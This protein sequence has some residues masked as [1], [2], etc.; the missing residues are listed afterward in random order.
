MQDDGGV[1]PNP[2]PNAETQ[3]WFSFSFPSTEVK[4]KPNVVT[5]VAAIARTIQCLPLREGYFVDVKDIKVDANASNK[6]VAQAPPAAQVEASPTETGTPRSTAKSREYYKAR[7]ERFYAKYA[8]EKL[9]Q[10]DFILDNSE[11]LEEEVFRKLVTKYGPEPPADSPSVN[12]QSSPPG[13]PR[14]A[15]NGTLAVAS[16]QSKSG[17]STPRTGADASNND[18]ANSSG[19]FPAPPP[20]Q[21]M[22]P[23]PQAPNR[24][25]YRDRMVRFYQKWAPE[26]VAQV[27]YV[28]DNSVGEEE[29][30]FRR[31]VSKY[32]PEPPAP[33]AVATVE[34][35]GA[36]SGGE[37][38]M[39]A[40]PP[41]QLQ[42][43]RS[44]TPPASGSASNR[45]PGSTPPRPG[46]PTKAGPDFSAEATRMMLSPECTEDLLA[47][48]IPDWKSPYGA[49][50]KKFAT[51]K[52]LLARKVYRFTS[53]KAWE[54]RILVLTADEK[55]LVCDEQM[56]VRRA[57]VM[58]T[59]SSI[60]MIG[61]KEG[62]VLVMNVV[63]EHELIVRH[64][65]ECP[66]SFRVTH[67]ASVIY[68]FN[69]E[70]QVERADPDE[71]KS[72]KAILSE[73]NLKKPK[74]YVSP[75]AEVKM[76]REGSLSPRTPRSWRQSPENAGNNSMGSLPPAADG[77]FAAAA[78][79]KERKVT[80]EDIPVVSITESEEKGSAALVSPRDTRALS[81]TSQNSDGTNNS[82]TSNPSFNTMMNLPPAQTGKGKANDDLVQKPSNP[83]EGVVR[84]RKPNSEKELRETV[85]DWEA[86][87]PAC[88]PIGDLSMRIK[89]CRR[90]LQLCAGPLQ[91]EDRFLSID[92]VSP[93]GNH[94]IRLWDAQTKELMFSLTSD[95]IMAAEVTTH[96]L[97]TT[98]RFNLAHGSVPMLVLTPHKETHPEL[99]MAQLLAVLQYIAP[100]CG[101]HCK[102]ETD[103]VAKLRDL[104][105][106]VE[107]Q[108]QGSG[109]IVG[110][111]SANAGPP[112]A[113]VIPS[114]TKPRGGQPGDVVEFEEPEGAAEPD[115]SDCLQAPSPS[116][117]P[118]GSQPTASSAAPSTPPLPRIAKDERELA[119]Q[120]PDLRNPRGQLCTQFLTD[121][122]LLARRVLRLT[123][124]LN[125]E[126]RVLLLLSDGKLLICDEQ[127]CVRRSLDSR[128][129]TKVDIVEHS[130]GT[131]LVM[132]V[133]GE[134]PLVLA[135]HKE[136]PST[137][138][139]DQLLAVLR[140][141]KPRL[142]IQ[143]HVAD[144]IAAGATAAA[145]RLKDLFR[146]AGSA[147]SFTV[148]SGW[149]TRTRSAVGEGDVT[150]T[151]SSGG[152]ASGNSNSVDRGQDLPEAEVDE[153][154]RDLL[155]P[156]DRESV[157]EFSTPPSSEMQLA[158]I[159]DFKNPVGELCQK[160][161]TSKTWIARRVVRLTS[162]LTWEGRVLMILSD[163]KMLIC[164]EQCCV[165]RS[166]P[167]GSITAAYVVT[168]WEGTGILFEVADD[169][170]LI[171][172]PHRDTRFD[173][174]VSQIVSVVQF[175]NPQLK[176]VATMSDF[177]GSLKGL[178][179]RAEGQVRM[180]EPA[181]KKEA[182]ARAKSE[183]GNALKLRDHVL[184][185]E[186]AEEAATSE[187]GVKG[188]E[189]SSGDTI[190]PVAAEL[191]P[192][193]TKA[194]QEALF[195]KKVEEEVAKR[196]EEEARIRLAVAEAARKAAE[197]EAAR[198]AAAEKAADE[199]RRLAEAEEAAARKAE[200]E[201]ALR[202][203][204]AARRVEAQLAE[205]RRVAEEKRLA[206]ERVIEEARLAEMRVAEERAAAERRLAEE[207]RQAEERAAEEARLAAEKQIAE[208]HAAEHRRLMEE[209][210][211]ADERAAEAARLEAERR[212]AEERRHAAE[213]QAAAERQALVNNSALPPQHVSRAIFEGVPPEAIPLLAGAVV[214]R[215]A[216]PMD[217]DG[218][219]AVSVAPNRHPTANYHTEAEPQ[220]SNSNPLSHSQ[221][222]TEP[223]S[224]ASSEA[225]HQPRDR[226]LPAPSQSQEPQ[227]QPEP[228]PEAV[229]AKS[230][231]PMS[232][233]EEGITI[234]IPQLNMDSVYQPPVAA[235]P[236]E[237]PPV[238]SEPAPASLGHLSP[239]SRDGSRSVSAASTPSHG[240]NSVPSPGPTPRGRPYRTF[241]F[242]TGRD[243]LAV[244]ALEDFL[245]FIYRAKN[246]LE[247][248]SPPQSHSPSK[249][250]GE[251]TDNAWATKRVIGLL[252]LD[253]SSS[254]NPSGRRSEGESPNITMF[255]VTLQGLL[256][257]IE[258]ASNAGLVRMDSVALRTSDYRWVEQ[259][260]SRFSDQ[261]R[262]G[263]SSTE[264]ADRCARI[265]DDAPI[266]RTDR[267]QPTSGEML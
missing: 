111:S 8:P 139:L 137:L 33:S 166:I 11:G 71:K 151:D 35:R 90:Y 265:L 36:G 75:A 23:S 178:F 106:N 138:S 132:E 39:V 126:G 264:Q 68:Y 142:L 27:D 14:Q 250:E 196:L 155:A 116:K 205:E 66:P 199:Q 144:S 217:D 56:K 78:D 99:T 224:A 51:P 87:Q 141:F 154:E 263:V 143:S 45:P 61:H 214:T 179:E 160:F 248:E 181:S 190:Q 158:G 176:A 218:P 221:S 212:M 105:L 48:N 96:R 251:E 243:V 163:G 177:D 120:V 13:T 72:L 102:V 49:S 34:G 121:Q 208:A 5:D 257:A 223:H 192:V 146:V 44:S 246:Q 117:A 80:F 198:R 193:L 107:S 261:C 236:Q 1:G 182:R 41:I 26:K 195:Q 10:V 124:K 180:K 242:K 42:N 157:V 240:L 101:I 249:A 200:E 97:G 266:H 201:A 165:R 109:P 162:K 88:Q 135:P 46:T 20:Q 222:V 82:F 58:D 136:T 79:R 100:S 76:V 134:T 147:L 171:I 67:I 16:P 185:D 156:L 112:A 15:G 170:N 231:S 110:G 64:H 86:L 89:F 47:R 239:H 62:S 145:R 2:P 30:I 60:L 159:P 85:P 98:I 57:V 227:G 129:L 209:K 43:I 256:L 123:S 211:L 197:E 164:D 260:A 53:K 228:Q 127:C 245:Q 94:L 25:F 188:A 122:T 81:A 207:K 194:E 69:K 50:C 31:L 247:L 119:L 252:C 37:S 77:S 103:T 175:F 63:N 206:D 255:S 125:W 9:S 54:V 237:K 172:A 204:E 161:V 189:T 238:Q 140:F 186:A 83:S 22:T 130:E 93:P 259:T 4:G 173:L 219:V 253:D 70:C 108:L 187:H 18:K 184:D 262:R 148:P 244:Y 229:R 12:G 216:E 149:L 128:L 234:P 168:H 241:R 167:C 6:K 115:Q 267:S 131:A 32:G 226:E 225:V 133:Q 174:S 19:N 191:A 55:I 210:R 92:I 213:K 114:V 113:T 152:F 169:H 3:N 29:D 153:G 95:Q 59:V 65:E 28:L 254:T 74:N 104:Y 220:H 258:E 52:T 233:S 202:V 73:R 21:N 232:Q 91:W 17:A 38:R 7:M 203:V 183:V 230:A 150:A 235:T 40:P 84:P 215:S 118:N 24:Q